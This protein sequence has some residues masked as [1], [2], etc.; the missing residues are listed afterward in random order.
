LY[1]KWTSVDYPLDFA[2]LLSKRYV[3]RYLS[4]VVL[5]ILAACQSPVE[6]DSV[7]PEVMKEENPAATDFNMEDSDSTAIAIANEVMEAM[8]GRAKYDSARY[9]AWNFFGVRRLLWDKQEDLARIE[10]NDG[11]WVMLID[12]ETEEGQVIRDGKIYTEPDSVAYFMDVAKQI[13]VNDSYWLVFPAKLKDS[14][15]TL[16]YAGQ[17]TIQVGEATGQLADVLQLTFNEVGFTPEN[18]YLA[19]VPIDSDRHVRQWDY[20]ASADVDTAIFSMPWDRY[21]N[22]NG[23][24]LSS[25]RGERKVSEIGV[26]QT[27]DSTAF[28]SLEPYN[29]P[30]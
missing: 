23:V 15:V 10:F 12:L 2:L 21:E 7:A 20:F 8:G 24:F 5:L 18:K 19:Y 1:P 25:D 3:M 16:T 9:F 29:W 30:K 4:L 11:D 6:S 14:G 22:Y 28:T 26:L 13:W 27:V 17:D